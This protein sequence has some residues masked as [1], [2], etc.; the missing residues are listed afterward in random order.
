[1]QIFG[2]QEYG[3]ASVSQF[4][5]VDPPTIQPGTV[6]IRPVFMGVNPADINVRIGARRDSFPVQFPMAMG[7]EAAGVVLDVDPQ[8]P[9]AGRLS[10]G[11]WVFGSTAPG[12]GAVADEAALLNADA[13]VEI[14]NGVP[15]EM[16]VTIPVAAG[17]AWDALHEIKAQLG[18][19]SLADKTLLIIGAGGGVGTMAIQLARHLGMKVIGATSTAEKQRVMNRYGAKHVTTVTADG[20]IELGWIDKANKLA[21]DTPSGYIDAI[22]DVAGKDPL[23]DAAQV[24]TGIPIV[25]L[26]APGTA[27]IFGGSGVKR[28]RTAAVFS[29]LAGLL[30]ANEFTPRISA[31]HPF[32]EAAEAF[33]TVEA[34]HAE[35]K[36]VIH[37][38]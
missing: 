29:E 7:R 9:L 1:M 14:P 38:T 19:G 3:P 35:G 30:A 5:E 37:N 13:T 12:Y 25:S 26:A 24:C 18:G 10:K 20:M 17:S 21:K 11:D 28:R 27:E 4:I 33:A 2:F 34:G 22:L 16:A 36:V 6:L 23:P 31:V 15:A 8:H 32:A